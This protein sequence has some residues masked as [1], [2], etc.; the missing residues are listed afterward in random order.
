[1]VWHEI[2]DESLKKYGGLELPRVLR[3][4]LSSAMYSQ[5]IRL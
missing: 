2:E 5:P 3:P 1:M 4:V